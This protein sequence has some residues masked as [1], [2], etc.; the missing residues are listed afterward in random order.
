MADPW[1]VAAESYQKEQKAD[2]WA[3]AAEQYKSE[4]APH[5]PVERFFEGAQGKLKEDAAGVGNMLRHPIDSAKSMWSS[6]AERSDSEREAANKAFAGRDPLG[7]ANH[8]LGYLVPGYSQ[9]QDIS[10]D[11]TSGDANRVGRGVMGGAEIAAGPELAESGRGLVN[12]ARRGV[13]AYEEFAKPSVQ[14]AAAKAFT[15]TPTDSTFLDHVDESVAQIK[16]L[17]PMKDIRTNDL[18]IRAGEMAEKKLGDLYDRWLKQAVRNHAV[19]IGDEVVARYKASLPTEPL[20][21]QEYDRELAEVQAQYAGK[22]IPVAEAARMKAELNG[23]LDKFYAKSDGGRQAVLVGGS[24]E[25]LTKAT[26]DALSDGLDRALD[27]ASTPGGPRD[28]NQT[29]RG[30]ID[31]IDYGKRRRNMSAA[32]KPISKLAAVKTVVPNVVKGF[33]GGAGPGA[34]AKAADLSNPATLWGGQVD[35]WVR[36]MYKASGK[37]KMHFAEPPPVNLNRRALPPSLRMGPVP[38]STAPSGHPG[39]YMGRGMSPAVGNR[40]LGPATQVQQPG[41][42]TQNMVPVKDSVTGKIT[43]V[44]E[45]YAPGQLPVDDTLPSRRDSNKPLGR[46]LTAKQLKANLA[47]RRL[48]MRLRRD[49]NIGPRRMN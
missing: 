45:H 16:D 43:Y 35:P 38:T 21:R 3:R 23:R 24:S 49:A 13:K 30:I 9:L 27:P 11:V 25:A 6:Y 18:H 46:R 14:V 37:P 28:I 32:S 41:F 2:P 4:T 5:S 33:T 8:E 7:Y 39:P 17:Q 42:A 22:Y 20:L 15:P 19:V 40:T 1:A 36:K 26:R 31:L 12:V 47:M 44:P 10:A 48:Q 29:R 34:F